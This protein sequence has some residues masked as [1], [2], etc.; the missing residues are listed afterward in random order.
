M[1]Y[2]SAA[3]LG[4]VAGFFIGYAY[5]SKRKEDYIHDQIMET[6]QYLDSVTEKLLEE[7]AKKSQVENSEKES[8]PYVNYSGSEQVED[9]STPTLNE[10]LNRIHAEEYK[11]M[12]DLKDEVDTYRNIRGETRDQELARRNNA[13]PIQ[14]TAEEFG[15]P[16][17]HELVAF[18]LYA[19]G[20]LTGDANEPLE[21]PYGMIGCS[22]ADLIDLMNL[23]TEKILY[24]R[25][26][27]YQL[28]I[29]VS[30]DPRSYSDILKEQPHLAD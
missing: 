27:K 6:R 9:D 13:K 15:Q 2:I 12:D 1:R 3:I 21:D 20:T 4:G 5:C 19:D 28:E 30:W 25:N 24:F 10:Y 26:E 23:A 22:V 8:K 29:E 7:D 18:T 14:I 17:D 11:S 16:E